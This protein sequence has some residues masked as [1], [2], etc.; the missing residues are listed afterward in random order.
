MIL[1]TSHNVMVIFKII[2]ML[3]MVL[4]SRLL[5]GFKH[6]FKNQTGLSGS[7]RNETLIRLGKL[8][9]KARITRNRDGSTS[10]DP[11]PLKHQHYTIL[12]KTVAFS[13]SFVSLN[14]CPLFLS[15]L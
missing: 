10:Y 5:F 8:H 2:Q 11:A 15:L 4:L 1:H 3:V 14:R 12:A 6:G 7:T 13:A 9:K